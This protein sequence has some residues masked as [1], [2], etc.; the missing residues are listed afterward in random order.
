MRPP[1]AL[2]ASSIQLYLTCS[3]KWRFQYLDRLPRIYTSGNQAFG[4]S[5][6]AALNWLHKERKQNRNPP[7][8]EVLQIFEADWYA[9]TET[10]GGQEIRFGDSAD[11]ATLLHKG[12][13]LLAQ[14]YHMTPGQV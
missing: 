6:H 3:L 13:E 4:T 10:E 8:A 12:K 14:Y 5:I 9:Q 7:L 11:A 2:S 1:E